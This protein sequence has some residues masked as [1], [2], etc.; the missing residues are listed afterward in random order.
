MTGESCVEE[1]SCDI[2][3]ETVVDGAA[4][5]TPVTAEPGDDTDTTNGECNDEAAV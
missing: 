4:S 1:L 2:S 5:V 3:E